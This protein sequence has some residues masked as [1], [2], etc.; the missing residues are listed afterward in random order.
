M[1]WPTQIVDAR[2][3]QL[4]EVVEGR[5]AAAP[6]RWLATRDPDK[7]LITGLDLTAE[8]GQTVAIVGPTGAGKTTLVNLLLRF[9][10]LDGGRITLDGHDIT[11]IP[12]RELRSK[13][14]M[15]LQDTWLFGDTIWENLRYG[16]PDATDAQILEAAQ[17]TYVDRFVHSLPDGFD[18]VINDEGDNISAGQKQLLTI[19]RAF[20]A[21]PA[22]LILDEATSS[23]DTRT[24]A[25]RRYALSFDARRCLRR[26]TD[27]LP[28]SLTT[29]ANP[30]RRPSPRLRH[31]RSASEPTSQQPQRVD[32]AR[33]RL[34][35]RQP[36]RQATPGCSCA[37]CSVPAR[38]AMAAA[39]SLCRARR[40]GHQ[41]ATQ[42]RK[43]QPLPEDLQHH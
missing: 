5:D 32:L 33:S 4:L 26:L 41:P 18:T 25:R 7:P 23:V 13:F 22:I 34:G 2:S 30:P 38:R 10:E 36:S 40:N 6:A 24:E 15:V 43:H 35:R 39:R 37:D 29:S 16:N 9:Y 28:N 12:R 17:I 21:D 20:L 27:I 1:R 19:A 3:G 31:F 42:R 11:A 8:P 14:G